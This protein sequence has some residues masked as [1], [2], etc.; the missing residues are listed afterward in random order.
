MPLSLRF[1]N[2][3]DET[4]TE[5]EKFQNDLTQTEYRILT[6]EILCRKYFVS[7]EEI[8]NTFSKKRF[9]KKKA[10]RHCNFSF[11]RKQLTAILRKT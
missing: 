1:S 5:T 8:Y 6:D 4:F 10:L 11:N 9:P 7:T 3:L 2:E